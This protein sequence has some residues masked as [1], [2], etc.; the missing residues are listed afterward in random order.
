MPLSTRDLAVGLLVS[1]LAIFPPVFADTDWQTW[2]PYRPGLY[3]G[4]RPQ[5]PDSVLMGL[6][7]TGGNDKNTFLNS[8]CPFDCLRHCYDSKSHHISGSLLTWHEQ[9]FE[10][11]ANRMMV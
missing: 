4:V 3:F 10:I 5:I 6:M 2:G 9:I 11:P 7:W 8:L 1:A